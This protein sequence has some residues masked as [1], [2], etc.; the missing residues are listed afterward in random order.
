V[1]GILADKDQASMV[2]A[3][4]SV[5]DRVVVTQPPLVERQG[6]PARMVA[7]FEAALGRKHVAF[8]RDPMWALDLA[9][10][11]ARVSDLVVVTGSMFLVGHIRERWVPE[12]RI[13]RRRTAR[14]QR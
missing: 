14:L 1:C 3:L 5:A 8:E 6:D 10:E 12:A 9:L 7:L 11:R 2:R 4:A 13:L